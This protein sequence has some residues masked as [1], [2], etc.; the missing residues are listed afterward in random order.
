MYFDVPVPMQRASNYSG[1][2]SNGCGLCNVFAIYSIILESD[3]NT[4]ASRVAMRGADSDVPLSEQVLLD[5]SSDTSSMCNF[6]IV[7]IH[8]ASRVSK[9]WNQSPVHDLCR[10]SLK[11]W[12]PRRSISPG[13]YSSRGFRSFLEYR[14]PT[15]C[16]LPTFSVSSVDPLLSIVSKG[17]GI[18]DIR[19]LPAADEFAS[20][21]LHFLRS[22]GSL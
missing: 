21:E 22:G 12:Q 6:R 9:Y 5:L 2:G 15:F 3:A 18:Y 16:S 10:Q 7:G 14:G 4:I 8:L 17:C 11:H 1:F 19:L 13:H 20:V